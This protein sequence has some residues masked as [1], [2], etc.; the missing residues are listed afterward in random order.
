M[1]VPEC[2]EEECVCVCMCVCVC[3]EKGGYVCE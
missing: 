3:V 1:F 2:K